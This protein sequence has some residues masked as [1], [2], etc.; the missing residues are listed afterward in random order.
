LQPPTTLADIRE[1]ASTI[2]ATLR[3]TPVHA[4][5]LISR[6]LAADIRFK[7][8]NLQKTGSFKSRGA[9][10]ALLNLDERARGAGVVTVSAGN[11][12]QALAWAAATVGAPC[13]VVMPQTASRSKVEASRAY[14]ASVVLESSS[15][16]AFQR[17]QRIADEEGMTLVHPFDDTHI[18]AGAGTVGLELIHEI[19]DAASV[20]VP[21]GGGGLIAGVATAVKEIS[22]ST[23]VYGVEP[24]GAAAMRKSLDAGHPVR[25][26]TAPST[27]ADGLAAPMAGDLTFA[28]TR[29]YV[30][31]VVLVD[32]ETIV[33]ALRLVVTRTKLLVEPAGAAALAAVM[34]GAI[35]AAPGPVVVILS[36][37][38]VDL[39]RLAELTSR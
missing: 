36:G 26:D 28:A 6:Q 38:N 5:T 15:M 3:P 35:P 10:N 29:R 2:A 34:S 19:P 32:D 1:A 37:G 21:I 27:I 11:H 30:D 18:A 13:T 4:S 7:C 22:P 8:E 14:G 12:A 20:V 17:C 39:D 9:L 31:D 23:R 33:E 24:A 16:A 25:L